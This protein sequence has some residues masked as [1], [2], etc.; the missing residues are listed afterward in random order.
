LIVSWI[1]YINEIDDPTTEL[2]NCYLVYY[3]F[4]NGS[5]YPKGNQKTADITMFCHDQ[6]GLIKKTSFSIELGQ[7]SHAL[8]KSLPFH[9]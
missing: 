4:P 1:E 7:E 5:D 3:N 2:G 8:S 9:Q 6:N